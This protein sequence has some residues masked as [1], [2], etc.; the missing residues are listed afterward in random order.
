[1]NKSIRIHVYVHGKKPPP[2]W[3][4]MLRLVGLA[5]VLFGP[6]I[7]LESTAMQWAGF[8]VLLVVSFLLLVT[9][10]SSEAMTIQQARKKLDDLEAQE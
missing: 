1:M 4:S 10:A 7:L 3:H 5:S 2:F 8:I 9:V 6:G